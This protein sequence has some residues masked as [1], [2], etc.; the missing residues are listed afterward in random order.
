MD[1]NSTVCLF[2]LLFGLLLVKNIQAIECKKKKKIDQFGCFISKMCRSVPNSDFL[3]QFLFL[4]VFMWTI[5]TAP[6]HFELKKF[7]F[8]HSTLYYSP[9][10]ASQCLLTAGGVR[11]RKLGILMSS[12][13][14]YFPGGALFWSYPWYS[15]KG[16]EEGRKVLAVGHTEGQSWSMGMRFSRGGR[17]CKKK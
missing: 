3:I 7:V 16:T 8:F 1:L 11:C 17:S 13:F 2:H 14:A 4:L 6:F 9:L 15:G 5:Y 10:S 12:V